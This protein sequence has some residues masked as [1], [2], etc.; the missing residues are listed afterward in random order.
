MALL[1]KVVAV[2]L[3]I[4]TAWRATKV[5]QRNKRRAL[6]WAFLGLAVMMTLRMS[7]GRALDAWIQ[8]PDLSYLLK[9]LFGGVLAPA[10]LLTFLRDVSG[11]GEGTSTSRFRTAFPLV[12]ATTMSVLFFAEL[13]PYDSAFIL[14]DPVASL[15]LLVYTLV[16]L[17]FLSSSL[18]SGMVVCWRWGRESGN[19]ALGWGLRIIGVG[20]ALGVAYA[21]VRMAAL[22]ALSSGAGALPGNLEDRLA[23]L[24]LLVA[25][26]VIVVGSTLP[27]VGRLHSWWSARRNL[28]HLY[29]LWHDLTECVPAVRLEAARERRFESLDPRAVQSRLYRR[30]IEIRDAVLALGDHSSA[31]ARAHA[32]AHVAAGGLE[33]AEAASAVEACWLALALRARL[34]GESAVPRDHRPVGGGSDLASEISS[35]VRLADAYNSDLVRSFAKSKDRDHTHPLKETVA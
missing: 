6:W 30:G 20:L 15:A 12:T 16:L 27:A 10:A 26:F 31:T 2:L 11:H 35:L 5:W 8:V 22:V 21:I 32:E 17:C 24:L 34:R 3:W 23:S 18:F 4:T 19:G 33:G 29:P 28:L 9:H 13:Q 1:E 7:A 14:S 25:L